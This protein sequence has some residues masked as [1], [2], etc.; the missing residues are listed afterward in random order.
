MGYGDDIMATAEV[1]KIKRKFKNHKIL[2]G[3]G[4]KEFLS[5]VFIHNPNID[6]TPFIHKNDKVIW[7]RNYPGKRPYTDYSR[8]RK[9]RIVFT[10]YCA[11]KG[12]LFFS[13]QEIKKAKRRIQRLRPFIVIEPNIRK[14]ASPNKDWG[15]FKWQKVV[16]ALKDRCTFVQLGDNHSKTLRGVTRL[17]TQDFRSA[18]AILSFAKLFVGIEGGLHHAAAALGIPGVI[19]F[20]GRVSPRTMG[21]CL[22]VNLYVKHPESPCGWNLACEHCRRCMER[23]SVSAVTHNLLKMLRKRK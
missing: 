21:Y 3:D 17:V 8:S 13:P 14:D 6:H 15:F 5:P 23:I 9:N 7:V 12:E 1:K 4:E 20:G 16:N 19:I 11:S 2:I 22:H 18:C 10:D